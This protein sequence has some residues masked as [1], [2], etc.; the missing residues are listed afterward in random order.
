MQVDD[1]GWIVLDFFDYYVVLD[2][3][4]FVLFG[5]QVGDGYVQ[6]VVVVFGVWS[7][8][9]GD[10]FVVV[11]KVV[12][13]YVQGFV[14]VVVNYVQVDFVVWFYVV[15]QVWQVGGFVD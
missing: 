5:G 12:Y 6:V 2:I 1:C 11:W 15:Y 8:Y 10:F 14:L 9:R 13:C 7:V 4:V 3:Q